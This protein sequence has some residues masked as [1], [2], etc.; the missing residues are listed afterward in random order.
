MGRLA[1]AAV[2]GVPICLQLDFLACGNGQRSIKLGRHDVVDKLDHFLAARLVVEKLLQTG[3]S[4]LPLSY[5]RRWRID[6]DRVPWPIQNVA[7]HPPH[8]HLSPWRKDPVGSRQR[9]ILA[10][11]RKG[12]LLAVGTQSG[13]EGHQVAHAQL[14]AAEKAGSRAGAITQVH[15]V[16]VVVVARLHP[17]KRVRRISQGALSLV[18]FD[19][20]GIICRY[21]CQNHVIDFALVGRALTF[22]HLV[23]ATHRTRARIRRHLDRTPEEIETHAIV[24]FVC[25]SAGI[26]QV[27]VPAAYAGFA[28]ATPRHHFA[29]GNI[30]TG[31][32]D[33]IIRATD[34]TGL[35][36]SRG[37]DLST[38]HMQGETTEV[39]ETD[40]DAGALE[41]ARGL[42][43]PAMHLHRHLRYD[44]VEHPHASVPA[45]IEETLPN[46]RAMVASLSHNFPVIQ[47]K[48]PRLPVL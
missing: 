13:I 30:D 10:K 22:V 41:A 37:Y 46:A 11:L 34:A 38:I 45:A 16:E 18:G 32:V 35:A 6:N 21:A 2:D 17:D 1:Q 26:E 48:G 3:P 43:L 19:N 8:K 33:D 12:I 20:D 23:A 31:L 27:A 15:V 47:D 24:A 9:E 36:A 28:G 39:V 29:A 42:K 25:L 40:P 5:R 14:L 7:D 4:R 44:V